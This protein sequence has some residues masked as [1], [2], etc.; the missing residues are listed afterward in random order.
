MAIM[1]SKKRN[2]RRQTKR[3]R[4][5]SGTAAGAVK[6]G[7]KG[8]EGNSKRVK[9]TDAAAAAVAPAAVAAPDASNAGGATRLFVGNLPYDV[10]EASLRTA[11]APA[12][13]TRVQWMTDKATGK[14]YG[15]CFV[16]VASGVDGS[17]VLGKHGVKLKGRKI[18]VNYE[19][20]S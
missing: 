3:E 16:E 14:F 10:D 4:V 13:V 9:L 1:E 15:S 17:V 2:E 6:A 5:V 7:G 8:G 18:R 19:K 20:R 12:N 11:L